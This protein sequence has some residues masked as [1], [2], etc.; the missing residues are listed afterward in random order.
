MHKGRKRES[1]VKGVDEEKVVREGK[2][3][4]RG[5]KRRW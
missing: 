4:K 3:E 1:A 2:K 5:E